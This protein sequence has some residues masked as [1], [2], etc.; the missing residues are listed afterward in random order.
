MNNKKMSNFLDSIIRKLSTT[1]A[2]S[3]L[4]VFIVIVIIGVIWIKVE[5]AKQR[6]R[7]RRRNGG[8]RGR[9]NNNAYNN[10]NR[11]NNLNNLNNRYNARDEIRR[12]SAKIRYLQ[13]KNW[14]NQ[15]ICI[16]LEQLIDH[17]ISSGQNIVTFKNMK[18]VSL[19]KQLASKHRL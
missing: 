5:A 12:I 3:I 16:C 19:L 8:G 2:K 18:I 14:E 7:N 1:E 11:F 13:N 9:N 4:G 17:N 10:R 15:C 6:E